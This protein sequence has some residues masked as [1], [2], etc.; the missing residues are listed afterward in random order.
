MVVSKTAHIVSISRGAAPAIE[1]ASQSNGAAIRDAVPS[2]TASH[3][4]EMTGI[5]HTLTAHPSFHTQ[6]G[7]DLLADRPAEIDERDGGATDHGRTAGDQRPRLPR[8]ARCGLEEL[9]P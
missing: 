3:T 5:S 2:P 9:E 8:P 4:L 6:K 1:E 7:L